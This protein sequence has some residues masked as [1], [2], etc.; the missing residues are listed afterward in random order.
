MRYNR[1]SMDV[2]SGILSLLVACWALAGSGCGGLSDLGWMMSDRHGQKTVDE[3]EP[4]DLTE[5]V[6]E[7]TVF[8]DAQ[9][10]GV[11]CERVTYGLERRWQVTKT[12][13]QYGMPK[14]W[15]KGM[16]WANAVY[17][18]AVG[19]GVRQRCKE[20]ETSCQN[21]YWVAPF[22]IDFAYSLV[23][24]KTSRRPKLVHKRYHDV[25]VG[26]EPEARERVPLTCPSDVRIVAAESRTAATGLYLQLDG[27]GQLTE[28]ELARLRLYLKHNPTHSV[29]AVGPWSTT[30]ATVCDYTNVHGP[31]RSM[32][33]AETGTAPSTAPDIAPDIAPNTASDD[34]IDTTT[35]VGV[36]V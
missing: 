35:G 4:I 11:R 6:D 15:F 31:P 16:L 21:L 12:Y 3:S 28:P 34:E 8:A 29:F 33:G 24:Y 36:D 1:A 25:E 10:V 23:R 27:Q 13:R 22:A 2:R 18:L 19:L 17:G 14:N 20:G 26:N 30:S 9:S 5:T 32:C 7:H